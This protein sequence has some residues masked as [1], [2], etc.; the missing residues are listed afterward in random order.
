MKVS[1]IYQI[2]S[3]I[4][5]ERI[6]IGSAV[7]IRQRRYEHLFHLRKNKHHSRKLQRHYNKYGESDLVFIIVELCFPEFLTAR[8]QY[9][10]NK[11]K[12]WFNIRKI[13]ES[14]LGLKCSDETRQ[15]ISES[16]KGR[17]LS[18]K[19]RKNISEGHKGII[20]SEE[21]RQKMSKSLIGKHHSEETCKKIGEASKSR[22]HT[23]KTK[24][25]MSEARRG[26]NH[27]MFG[28]HHSR[29]VKKRISDS[30]K[31]SLELKRSLVNLK[32][33]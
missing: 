20:C 15:K 19:H 32:I 10:I 18:E 1:G 29:E 5:P 21:T 23:E 16:L 24:R 31:K 13:A 33:A 28:K 12:P 26:E 25:K 2:Q 9:Y 30:V 22:K 14:N 6:Y 11:L 17:I 4:K 27:L 3:K 8:E 7:S